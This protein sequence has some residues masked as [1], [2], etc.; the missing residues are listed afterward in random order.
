MVETAIRERIEPVAC[1]RCAVIEKAER[2]SIRSVLS[3]WKNAL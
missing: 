2:E 1:K 3:Q